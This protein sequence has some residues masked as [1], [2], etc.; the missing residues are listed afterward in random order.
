M[1]EGK[2]P[3]LNKKG[4]VEWTARSEGKKR[5]REEEDAEE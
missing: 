5:K 1:D 4:E 2:D 3:F